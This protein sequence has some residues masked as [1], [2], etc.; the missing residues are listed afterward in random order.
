MD[1]ALLQ[2]ILFGLVPQTTCLLTYDSEASPL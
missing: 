1:D 2:D